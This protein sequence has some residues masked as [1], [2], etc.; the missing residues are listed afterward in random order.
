MHVSG[1]LHTT[2][3]DVFHSDHD[4]F[5]K[6]AGDKPKGGEASDGVSQNESDLLLTG[7]ASGRASHKVHHLD[8]NHD[9]AQ[10]SFKASLTKAQNTRNFV[11]NR[12]GERESTTRGPAS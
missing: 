3:T 1:T 11:A 6:C 12:G 4:V 10:I 7:E 2:L 8:I 9:V 5:P